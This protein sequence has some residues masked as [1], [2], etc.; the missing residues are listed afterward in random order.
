VLPP[1]G[2]VI[3]NQPKSTADDIKYCTVGGILHHACNIW[4]ASS[5]ISP[6]EAKGNKETKQQG[7]TDKKNSKE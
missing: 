4:P 6:K 3:F 1:F 2:G 5:Q 7:P